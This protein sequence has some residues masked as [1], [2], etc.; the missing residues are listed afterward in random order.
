M[1]TLPSKNVALFVAN[2]AVMGFATIPL[3]PISFAFAVELTYPAPEAM[4]NGM[5]ILPNKV[6][7]ALMGILASNLSERNP[8]FALALFVANSAV[9]GVSAIFLREELRRLNYKHESTFV[10]GT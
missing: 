1:I 9:C 2:V 10:D 3:T 8:I 5:M 7:G 6:Y 4:S